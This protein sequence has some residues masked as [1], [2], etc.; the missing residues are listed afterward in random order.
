VA[1]AFKRKGDGFVARLDDVE[2]E[3]VVGL[4]EQTH[5]FVAPTPREP[6]GDAFDDLVARLGMPRLK[7][8]P[9]DAA[10]IDAAP[11]PRDP[12]MERL[13]PSANRQDPELAAEFRRLTEHGLRQRKAA[14][15]ATAISALRAGQ[16]AKRDGEKKDREKKDRDKVS[17]SLEQAQ[18]LV[19]ALTDVR[20]VLGERL[21]LETDDDA[22]AIHDRIEA[23]SEDDPQLYL[24][25]CYDFLTWLQE[26]LIQALM[27]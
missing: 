18:A 27:R 23:A 17:L 8:A 25:A 12:A 6:T 20:L 1:K 26:S 9:D 19:V 13:L 22:E 24:A 16:G 10:S 5:E 21:G 15:L 2:R 7:D 11:E 14:N 3:I 4:L